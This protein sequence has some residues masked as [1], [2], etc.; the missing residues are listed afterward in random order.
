MKRPA[1]AFL[2]ANMP[3][4]DLRSLPKEL[5]LENVAYAW[6]ARNEASWAASVPEDVFL[7]A[8]LPYASVNEQREAWRK[9]FYDRFRPWV[10]EC[11]TPGEAAL[12]L[13]KRLFKEVNVR[14]HPTMRPN[15]P[16]GGQPQAGG[17]AG[18]E[19]ASPSALSAMTVDSPL[20]FNA[21][22][23]LCRT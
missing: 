1:L 4:I 18:L 7:N 9:N 8:V 22:T 11:K 13:N 21:Q 12:V 16:K 2:L 6:K 19:S 10:A 20:V 17:L 5:L 3:E 23:V 15:P 14:Y